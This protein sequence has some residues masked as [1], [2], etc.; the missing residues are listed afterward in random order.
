MWIQ[1]LILKFSLLIDNNNKIQTDGIIWSI[2]ESEGRIWVFLIFIVGKNDFNISIIA[3]IIIA[4]TSN[5][6]S[7]TILIIIIYLIIFFFIFFILF[8]FVVVILKN[9]IQIM[10]MKKN[11]KKKKTVNF[12]FLN[13]INK[14]RRD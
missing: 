1:K 5:N 6:E 14:T 12:L 2:S 13:L 10:R 11:E 7:I 9:K 8:F 4:I 3:K